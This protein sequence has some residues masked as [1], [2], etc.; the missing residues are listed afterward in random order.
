MARRL[1]RSGEKDASVCGMASSLVQLAEDGGER[2]HEDF[3]AAV[4]GHM[5]D[6]VAPVF[7]ICGHDVGAGEALGVLAGLDEVA[8]GSATLVDQYVFFVGAV[9]EDVGHFPN[10]FAKRISR[11][12]IYLR[13]IGRRIR[14]IPGVPEDLNQTGVMMRFGDTALLFMLVYRALDRSR[15]RQ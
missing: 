7:P 15:R 14:V 13:V 1:R 8:D 9:E 11:V 4:V 3:V 2:Q 12:K 6:P 10:P 5:H